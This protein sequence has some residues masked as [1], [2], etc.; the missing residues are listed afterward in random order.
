M[1][2]EIV[3]SETI[4][5]SSPTPINL[6]SFK[7]SVMDQ[8][9]VPVY[10]P[11]AFFY[12]AAPAEA[13][14]KLKKSLSETLTHFYPLA[15]RIKDNITVIECNDD[16]AVYVEARVHGVLLSDFLQQP[17]WRGLNQFIPV[18]PYSP[19]SV[20]GPLLVVQASFLECGGLVM[21]L[22]MSHK[23]ADGI[24]GSAFI[25]A[26]A[27][28]THNGDDKLT[29]SL[30]PHFDTTAFRY[31]NNVRRDDDI[32]I[33]KAQL[34]KLE[35]HDKVDDN[36]V[37]ARR[38]VF[39]TKRF[40]FDA[41]KVVALKAK[42]ASETVHG[43]LLSDFLQ[44]PD[45]RGLNQFI[46]VDPF[47]PESLTGPLLVVQASFFDCGG[48]VI[49][50]CISHKFADG[51]T[52]SAFIRGWAA[53]THNDD[54]KLTPS[55]LPH[56]DATAFRYLDDR[57]DD[58]SIFKPQLR[59]LRDQEKA[60]AASETV[61]QPSR[62]E[63]V[64]SLIWGCVI[65]AS[66]RSNFK[67]RHQMLEMS[68]NLRKRVEPPLQKNS[69]GNLRSGTIVEAKGDNNCMIKDLAAELRKGVKEFCES[70]AKKL[71]SRDP[72][73]AFEIVFQHLKVGADFRRSKVT[74]IFSFTSWCNFKFYEA[75]FGWN[76]P[77]WVSIAAEPPVNL[78]ILRDT[79]DGGGVEAWV[80]LTKQE[81]ALFECEP[82]LLQFASLNPSVSL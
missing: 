7:L 16:G 2:I 66:T 73:D 81:M 5:P 36:H 69:I 46:P 18:D 21:G 24:T 28:I 26:W 60:K 47:S 32:S 22:C 44:K 6:R 75:D 27:A 17:D 76:K 9:A 67:L 56:F 53:I 38:S 52:G 68:V 30:L 70:K 61:E 54:D 82:Q 29:P 55:L 31:L 72:D 62:V 74:K 78:L 12:P 33:H 10:A 15:G 77:I 1:K 48:L 34:G 63:A 51:I 23:F 64:A 58:I 39:V 80:T 20:T 50:L 13:S 79:R 3:S 45:W 37:I 42:A 41:S 57:R 11:I 35:D 59:N 25:R 71:G 4:K 14:E 65:A 40:V 49:G 8:L 43:V 19:E